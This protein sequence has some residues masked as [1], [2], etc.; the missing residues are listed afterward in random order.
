MRRRLAFL[1]V[2][3]LVLGG[4]GQTVAQGSVQMNWWVIAAGGA[5]SSGGAVTIDDTLG[6]PVIG[7]AEGSTVS[8]GAGNWYPGSGPAAVSPLSFD[9]VPQGAAILLTWETAD[10]V[11]N[12]GFNLYRAGSPAG[13]LTRVNDELIPTLVPP[14]SPYGAV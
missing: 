4:M 2:G 9:A 8:L 3:A 7:P 1:R 12:L 10:E 14:G 11:D 13:P 5:P 6:Q